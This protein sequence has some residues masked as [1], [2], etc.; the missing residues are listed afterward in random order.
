MA[1]PHNTDAGVELR[2]TFSNGAGSGICMKYS[3]I[4]IAMLL[5]PGLFGQGAARFLDQ[6]TWGPTPASITQVQTMGFEAWLAAQFALNTSDLPDQP[7]LDSAGKNNNN[8]APVQAA[9]FEN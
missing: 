4:F 3:S 6:A 1:L 8:L 7:I 2:D 5:S 9:F